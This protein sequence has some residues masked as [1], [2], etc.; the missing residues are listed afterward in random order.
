MLACVA[1]GISASKCCIVLAAE[2][3]EEWVQV[4]LKS[5]AKK[6]PQ[7]QESRQLRRLQIYICEGVRIKYQTI[8]PGNETSIVTTL[9]SA[10]EKENKKNG[11][12]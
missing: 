11:E 4:N 10:I 8:L 1:G 7:V 2:L 3:R 12:R 6:V 5:T 9:F